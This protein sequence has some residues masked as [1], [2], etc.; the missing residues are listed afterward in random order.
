MTCL[1]SV[2]STT[3]IA[4]PLR[5]DRTT[6]E[7]RFCGVANRTPTREALG[8]RLSVWVCREELAIEPEKYRKAAAPEARSLHP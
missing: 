8:R 6:F 2:G 3:R 5:P 1:A 7:Q 4:Y